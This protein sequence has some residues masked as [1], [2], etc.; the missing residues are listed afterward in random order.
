MGPDLSPA[1]AF[2]HL[3]RRDPQATSIV[4]ERTAHTSAEVQRA[5]S[6]LAVR[7][8]A[9]GVRPGDR[10]A[11]AGRNSAAF[12]VTLLGAACVGAVF[13][14]V[15]FRLAPAEVRTLLGHCDPHTVVVDSELAAAYARLVADHAH[16]NWLDARIAMP[17]ADPT[18]AERSGDLEPVRLSADDLAVIMYTSG[19]SGTP[20]G[21]MLTHGNLWWSARNIDQVLD[22]RDDDVA[23][24]VAPMSHIGGLNAFTLRTLL[25]GGTVLSRRAFDAARTLTDLSAGVTCLFGVP[26]MFAAIARCPGFAT[27]DLSGVRAA[28]IAGSAAP[29]SLLRAYVERGLHLQQSWGMTET[30]P[31]ATYLPRRWTVEKAGSCGLPLPWTD[32]RLDDP[33]TGASVT[34]P[35]APGEIVVR[36]P[37]VTPGYWRAPEL[38]RA[39]TTP[40]GWLRTG[41]LAVRDEDGCLTVVG[42]LTQ[43]INTGGEKVFPCEVE[44]ALSELLG[45][46][47]HD[48]AVLGLPDPEWGETVVAVLE[49]TGACPPLDQVRELAAR[50]IARFKLPTRVV[51]VAEL[52]RNATGK[53]DRAALRALVESTPECP[54]VE[55]GAAAR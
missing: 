47:V 8:L 41:D 35:G 23:L 1:S 42:R 33:A 25:R 27:A 28:T 30:A 20:K 19:T 49:T 31:S 15:S 52:P 7:L 45:P 12:L 21:V 34:I 18:G 17:L 32:I 44:R 6:D 46:D 43:M 10:V 2:W 14:P 38:T 53:I 40:D 29:P 26:A 37:H 16:R 9:D 13:V 5:A 50:A 39:A 11:F 3:V 51:A 24:A 48:L 36:G 22:T 4:D 54:R 55:R